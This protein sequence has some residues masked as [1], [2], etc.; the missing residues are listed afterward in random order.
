MKPE[1]TIDLSVRKRVVENPALAEALQKHAD[2]TG[3]AKR[4]FTLVSD[5][6]PQ[7]TT[8]SVNGHDVQAQSIVFEITGMGRGKLTLVAPVAIVRVEG[9]ADVRFV[10][11]DE[12]GIGCADGGPL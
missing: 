10:P 8:V 3:C 9:E 11:L 7:G 5:G 4:F 2:R 12:N 6:T 1:I